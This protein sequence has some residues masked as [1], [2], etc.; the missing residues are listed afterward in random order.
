MINEF[1]KQDLGIIETIRKAGIF[2]SICVAIVI[3]KIETVSAQ[4]NGFDLGAY[5][6]QAGQMQFKAKRVVP[7]TPEAAEL[8]KYGNT[9]VSLFTGSPRISVPLYEQQGRISFPVSLSY[10]GGGFKPQ[11]VATWVGLGWA[12]NAGGVITRS[13]QGNPDV[14]E[15]YFSHGNFTLP[16]STDLYAHYDLVTDLRKGNREAQGDVYYYNFGNYSGKFFIKPDLSVV[17][18]TKD[19]FQINHCITCTTGYSYFTIKD[20]QGNL[21]EFRESEVTTMTID[22]GESPGDI[23]LTYYSY[24]YASSWYLSK[25]T[26]ADGI[27]MIDLEYYTPTE[28]HE[29]Y[30]GN[31]FDNQSITYSKKT[32]IS[33]APECYPGGPP[34][35]GLSNSMSSS[36]PPL[37]KTTRKYLRKITFKRLGVTTSYIDFESIADQRLDLIN[38][39]YPGERL[40]QTIKVYNKQSNGGLFQLGKEFELIYGYFTKTINGNTIYQRLRLDSVK[41]KPVDINTAVKPAYGFSYNPICESCDLE[42]S[43][44]H[45]GYSNGAI[46]TRLIPTIQIAAGE[47]YGLGA[48]REPD[49]GAALSGILTKITYP[50]RGY[51]TFIYEGHQGIDETG[52]LIEVGGIRIKEIIDYSFE[53]K[54]ASTKQYTYTKEDGSTSGKTQRPSYLSTSS[55]RKYNENC[56]EDQNPNTPPRCCDIWSDYIQ[57]NFTISASSVYG[58]GSIQG[59]HI[60]YTR[61]IETQNEVSNGLALGKTVYEYNQETFMPNDD[62]VGNGDL[63]RQTV[64]NNAD[65]LLSETINTYT[66]QTITSAGIAGYFPQAHQNQDNKIKLCRYISNNQTVYEWRLMNA[67]NTPA[68]ADSRI[69]KTKMA[70]SGYSVLSQE[71]YLTQQTQKIYDQVSNS[72]LTSTKEF[73]YGAAHMMPVKII[74]SNAG[75]EEVITEQ[76]Y[77]L[78]Y[79]VPTSGLDAASTGIKQLQDRNI[80]GAEIEKVQYRQVVGGTNKRYINGSITIYETSVPLPKDLYRL[81]I[82][83]PLTTF[84][85][86]STNGTFSYN[87]NYKLIG[88]FKYDGNTNLI[89]QTKAQDIPSA[90]VWDYNNKQVTA[91]VVNAEAES[92]AYSSFETDY[93]GHW[94]SIPNQS[95]KR[96]IGGITG[97][98]SYQLV[99]GNTVVKSGLLSSRIYLVSYWSK[100]GAVSVNSNTGGAGS[101]TGLTRNGWTYYEHV[102]PQSSTSVT[103]SAV[104]ANIDELRLYPKDAQMVSLTYEHQDG[105]MTSQSSPNN[106]ITYFEYDGYKRLVNVKD[107]EGNIVKNYKYNYGLG[108]A[109]TASTQTLFYNAHSQSIFYKNNCQPGTEPGPVVYMVHYGKYASSINQAD[110]NAKASADITANGQSYANE[111]GLCYWWN[112][113]A[114]GTF[115]KNN[116]QYWEGLPNPH[117]HVYTVPA[118]TYSSLISQEDANAKAA[119]DIAANGQAYANQQGFCSCT[120]VGHRYING[121]CEQGSYSSAGYEYFPGCQPNKNYRCYYYY[122]FSD[123]STSSMYYFCSATPCGDY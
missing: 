106:L 61:V 67:V 82:T 75:N 56:M 68:C 121:V 93:T 29:Q 111:N 30:G 57:E 55:H 34:G 17:K 45:W 107:D 102:L 94:N 104:S 112:A 19:N 105:V 16:N 80:V 11:D 74:Q 20:E 88:S 14:L 52:A 69:Y 99:S 122:A 27:E 3:F 8:G 46:N 87:S 44:D 40:L 118:H 31:F 70:I 96:V 71:K 22:P 1:M 120:Q 90:Y 18:K 83:Q 21:Y 101:V 6:I 33:Y 108:T 117:P 81:E 109:P 103:I 5:A 91:E 115:Y 32:Y 48:A 51:T 35:Q 58:L 92:V 79:T 97:K 86:S 26:S 23:A 49:L 4:E 95:G 116:C 77:A 72:Y 10:S 47:N 50:T 9:Q 59:S 73:T 113:A 89:Q 43:I 119:A 42:T 2:F 60:G 24:T 41:E 13:V 15:N 78:D 64:F 39:N 65:K 66:I 76:K 12:L 123:G 25:I 7:P 85:F 54:K 53:N 98:Y 84:Q 100:N 110:A 38:I 36:T 114:S 63:I 37:I 28:R 62:H